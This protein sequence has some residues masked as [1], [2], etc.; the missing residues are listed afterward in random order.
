VNEEFFGSTDQV[1]LMQRAWTLWA[2]LHDDPCYSFYGRMISL[3]DP[4]DDAV[5]RICALARLQ[6]ATSCQYLPACDAEH[7]CAELKARGMHA[8]RYEQLLGSEDALAASH[9][10]LENHALPEDITVTTVG[11]NT[12]RDRVADLAQLSLTCG[13]MPVSGS[14][15][16]GQSRTGV[17]L[18][19]TDSAGEAVATA[20][21]YLSNHPAGP[22][23]R[24]AFWGMLATRED[25]RG[26]RIALVLGARAIVSMWETWGARAFTTSVSADNTSSV[27]V[28][29][30]LGLTESVL[31]CIGCTDPDK[32]TN[33]LITK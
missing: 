27:A 9:R 15:M 22:H 6:G 11:A 16:R 18:L 21:S 33:G 17:C 26:Q 8:Y 19:A 5:D 2:L 20:S 1:T 25:R 10:M 31:V 24:D 13:V 30:R 32:F 3:S 28:C 29:N 14:A 12:S 4:G 7:F 23:G